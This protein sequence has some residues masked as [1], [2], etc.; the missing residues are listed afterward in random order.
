[1]ILSVTDYK[2]I[3]T[4]DLVTEGIGAYMKDQNLQAHLRLQVVLW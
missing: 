2:G 4:Y 3:G 1:M